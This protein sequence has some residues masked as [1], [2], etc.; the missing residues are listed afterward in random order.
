MSAKK[1]NKKKKKSSEL[2]NLS[3]IDGQTQEE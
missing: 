3:L 2:E 1:N